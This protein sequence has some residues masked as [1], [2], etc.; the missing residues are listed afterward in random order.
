MEAST[1]PPPRSLP[2]R[3]TLRLLLTRRV[4]RSGSSSPAVMEAGAPPPPCSPISGRPQPQVLLHHHSGHRYELRATR[5][6]R[7]IRRRRCRHPSGL[8]RDEG[9]RRKEQATVKGLGAKGPTTEGA[10]VKG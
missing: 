9:E 10:A 8:D 5:G 2:W 3:L 6:G 1:R 4:Q 7:T